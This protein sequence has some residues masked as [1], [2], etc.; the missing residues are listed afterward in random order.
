MFVV[1]GSYSVITTNLDAVYETNADFQLDPE[2]KNWK[3]QLDF[4]QAL[5]KVLRAPRS[6]LGVVRSGV[7]VFAGE[8]SPLEQSLSTR[9]RALAQGLNMPVYVRG[10]TP[11]DQGLKTARDELVGKRERGVPQVIIVLTDGEPS[12]CTTS[13]TDV[14]NGAGCIAYTEELA[15]SY[16]QDDDVII[17][18]IGV[19]LYSNAA[20][21]FVRAIATTDQLAFILQDFSSL[22]AELEALPREIFGT[23]CSQLFTASLPGLIEDQLSGVVAG[24]TVVTQTGGEQL[25]VEMF[26]E[27]TLTRNE[28]ERLMMEIAALAGVEPSQVSLTTELLDSRR[29]LLVTYSV[30]TV[31]IDG[32]DAVVPG[33]V[34]TSATT[35]GADES[36]RDADGLVPFSFG[37]VST[38]RTPTSGRGNRL[39]CRSASSCGGVVSSLTDSC[40][41]NSRC[42]RQGTCCYD[43]EDV[44]LAPEPTPCFDKCGEPG[45]QSLEGDACFC[46]NTCEFFGDCCEGLEADCPDLVQIQPDIEPIDKSISCAGYCGFK[47]TSAI[48]SCYCDLG[49]LLYGDCCDDRDDQC[50]E[51]IFCKDRCGEA[52]E[53]V[54]FCRDDCVEAGDCCP[55]RE[56]YCP[57]AATTTTAPARNNSRCRGICGDEYK[58]RGFSCGCD[59]T[60]QERGDCCEGRGGYLDLCA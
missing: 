44:C 17:V 13:P 56:E 14:G 22:D 29:R 40:S 5:D 52:V 51:P 59:A 60:C 18:T 54:C 12:E 36:S 39:A 43:Y 30:I 6:G 42:E 10:G 32:V 26:I 45:D 41:C 15:A 28:K 34:S 23:L 48:G 38:G 7:T 49:C 25:E 58:E 3:K 9:S 24:Y 16:R 11:T 21:N 57:T 53:D 37:E 27:G 35:V 4:V 1:D 19:R 8:S 55:D 47:L 46:E 31:T 20:E 50:G 33:T 2:E